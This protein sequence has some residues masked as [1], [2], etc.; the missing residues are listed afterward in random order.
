MVS[1][2]LCNMMRDQELATYL[3]DNGC[4]CLLQCFL[5]PNH[6]IQTKEVPNTF[7]TEQL[8]HMNPEE[9]EQSLNM[10]SKKIDPI[11]SFFMPEKP[12]KQ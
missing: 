9:R 11:Y 12:G 1:E 4:I 8:D 3:R 2:K 6:M 10:D 7:T 5:F